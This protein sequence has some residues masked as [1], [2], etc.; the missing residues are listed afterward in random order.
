MFSATFI[1]KKNQFD[2]EFH[3]LDQQIAKFAKQTTGYLGEETWKN[4]D[5]GCIS[6]VYYWATMDGLHELMQHPAHQQAKQKNANWLAGY[7]VI[8]AQVMRSYGDG[9]IAHP[10]ASML[11]E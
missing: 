8:I 4:T 5:T 1:F 9:S 7:Q 11:V 6:N 3:Q 10:T 2:Q